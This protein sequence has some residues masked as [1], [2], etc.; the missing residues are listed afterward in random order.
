MGQ[1]GGGGSREGLVWPIRGALCVM[2]PLLMTFICWLHVS[3][4]V[5]FRWSFHPNCDN[6]WAVW[7]S[8][9]KRA[10]Q[11]RVASYSAV[12]WFSLTVKSFRI[13][14]NLP[15]TDHTKWTHAKACLFTRYFY[16]IS[17]FTLKMLCYALFLHAGCYALLLHMQWTYLLPFTDL[18]FGIPEHFS[19]P[20]KSLE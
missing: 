17:V 16:I 4:W 12:F 19:W 8:G 14:D 11:F 2:Q 20:S 1:F 10:L 18:M 6:M 9:P 3:P 15:G 7:L 5:Q 13:T